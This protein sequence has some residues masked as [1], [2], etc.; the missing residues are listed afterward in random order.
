MFAI[1]VLL[2]LVVATALYR[3][4]DDKHATHFELAVRERIHWLESGITVEFRP[5]RRMAA[6]FAFQR[7]EISEQ[8]FIE[9]AQS[10]EL[11]EQPELLAIQWLAKEKTPSGQEVFPV[12]YSYTLTVGADHDLQT[13]PVPRA[14]LEQA[15]QRRDSSLS[16]WYRAHGMVRFRVVRPVFGE[17]GGE[18]L[19]FISGIYRVD[20]LLEAVLRPSEPISMDLFI[21]DASADVPG[22]FHQSRSVFRPVGP[23][24]GPF[25]DSRRLTRMVNLFGV[26]WRVI[27]VSQPGVFIAS[28]W[29]FLVIGIGGV[30]FGTILSTYL[31]MLLGREARVHQLVEL[32]TDELNRRTEQLQTLNAELENFAYI[33]SHD[34]RAPLRAVSQLVS[35]IEEDGAET[36]DVELIR[37]MRLIRERVQRMDDLIEGL[38]IYSRAGG[39]IIE[40]HDRV[41]LGSLLQELSDELPLPAHFRVEIRAPMPT[42]RGNALHLR[43]IFQNLLINAAAHHDHPES[44]MVRI[45]ARDEDKFWRLDIADNGPGIPPDERERVFRMFASTG[46]KDGGVHAGIGLALVRKLVHGYGGRID[47][48]ENQPRGV[49]FRIWWPK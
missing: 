27:A 28:P 33:A 8:E 2:G 49:R 38:L 17:R 10:A 5:L 3:L 7:G 16:P 26:D 29:G 36:M 37:R 47:M 39:T 13:D 12:H 6:V 34:L 35:S 32:R 41:P 19:G 4:D 24:I 23:N 18:L 20:L 9:L 30:L 46:G 31:R 15:R 43:Q 40:A 42:L 21:V 14:L 25:P 22:Y 11:S 45:S 1:T 44:G 48:I